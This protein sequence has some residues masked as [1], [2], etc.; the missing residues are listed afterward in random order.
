MGCIA[1]VKG[2][3]SATA[4][5]ADMPGMA[6]PITPIATPAPQ[7]QEGLDIAHERQAGKE[8]VDKAHGSLTK[9]ALRD[10]HPGDMGEKCIKDERNHDGADHRCDGMAGAC[11]VKALATKASMLVQTIPARGSA[12]IVTTMIAAMPNR[13]NHAAFVLSA[14]SSGS[15]RFGRCTT[16][17][18]Q[19]AQPHYSGQT[20]QR[21]AGQNMAT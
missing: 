14:R 12:D 19:Q 16:P 6:P 4:I 15:Y 18:Q 1:K 8:A 17:V 21:M 3:V 2:R 20:G 10:R 5:V 13:R 9:V 7:R 11:T